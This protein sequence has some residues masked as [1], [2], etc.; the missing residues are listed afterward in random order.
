MRGT[1]KEITAREHMSPETYGAVMDKAR[2]S[3]SEPPERFMDALRAVDLSH[4]ATE[5]LRDYL[6]LKGEISRHKTMGRDY[7]PPEGD[8]T[9]TR[10]PPTPQNDAW[11]YIE[12]I[13]SGAERVIE[14]SHRFGV[15]LKE[16]ANDLYENGKDAF[17]SLA[18]RMHLSAVVVRSVPGLKL[19]LRTASIQMATKCHRKSVGRMKHRRKSSA[20]NA[21]WG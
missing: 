10:L 6:L 16:N 1:R 20:M 9:L 8:M 13:R 4:E 19:R 21:I 7:S 17:P 5:R 2:E 11:P 18:D 3:L 14:A 15:S 12:A